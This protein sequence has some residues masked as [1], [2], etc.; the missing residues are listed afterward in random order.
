MY[1]FHFIILLL[2]V[3]IFNSCDSGG[4]NPEV[5][6][7]TDSNAVNFNSNADKD[8]GSCEYG[9]CI[10]LSACNYNSSASY[11]SLIHI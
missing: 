7:C 8:D 10:D 9:G 5:E 2:S 3:F 11:L 1:L 6:G 4:D